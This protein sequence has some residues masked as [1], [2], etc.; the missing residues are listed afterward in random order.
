M[1]PRLY[2]FIGP[3]IVI[4]LAVVG[5]MTR[6]ITRSVGVPRCWRCGARKVRRSRGRS[7]IDFAASLFL[8]RPFRC[9]GCRVRFYGLRFFEERAPQKER[10]K[11]LPEP[12]PAHSPASRLQT[13][14]PA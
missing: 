14:N 8:L 13:Q 11:P 9:T 10:I 2:A 1:D 4:V 5:L 3:A 6:C 7:S 12:T